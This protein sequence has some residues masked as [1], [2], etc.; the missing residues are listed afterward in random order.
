M[1][2]TKLINFDMVNTHDIIARIKIMNISITTNNLHKFFCYFS[3]GET[4]F[5]E[6][7]NLLHA[8]VDHS[9]VFCKTTICAAALLPPEA[10]VLCVILPLTHISSTEKLSITS[11]A[12]KSWSDHFHNLFRHQQTRATPSSRTSGQK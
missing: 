11:P 3:R 12:H 6:K 8:G 7:G 9:S 5:S 2:S 10:Q 1:Y 4:N